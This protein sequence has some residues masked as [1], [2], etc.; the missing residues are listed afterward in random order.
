MVT[1]TVVKSYVTTLRKTAVT[2]YNN[3]NNN[4][5]TASVVYRSEFLATERSCIVFAVRYEL[6]LCMLCRRK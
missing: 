6:N 5:N 4:N 1:Y 3:N 2:V